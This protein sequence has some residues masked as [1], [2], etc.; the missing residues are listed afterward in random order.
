[1]MYVLLLVQ[2]LAFLL[3]VYMSNNAVVSVQHHTNFST[4]PTSAPIITQHPP[5][6]LSSS[7][8]T[9][10]QHPPTPRNHTYTPIRKMKTTELMKHMLNASTVGGSDPLLTVSTTTLLPPINCNNSNNNINSISDNIDDGT[11]NELSRHN[12]SCHSSSAALKVILCFSWVVNSV[13]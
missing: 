3:T 10:G 11:S 13:I 7:S 2:L 12:Q 4:S 5:S 9:S 6:S 1:M 8:S